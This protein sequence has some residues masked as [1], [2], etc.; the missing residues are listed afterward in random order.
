M[1]IIEDH[2]VELFLQNRDLAEKTRIRYLHAIKIY[3]EFINETPTQWIEEAENEEEDRI[4]MRKRKIKTYQ[5][6]FKKFLESKNYTTWTIKSMIIPIRIFYKE[7]DIEIPDLKI[8]NT[9][10]EETYDDIPSKEDIRL[11]LQFANLKYRAIILLFSSSGMGVA[12]LLSIKYHDLL[13]SLKEYITIP[14]N[15]YIDIEELI[16]LI[17][18]QKET[19]PII[20][21]TWQLTRKKTGKPFI[22]FS[23]PESLDIL[24]E[25]LKSDPPQKLETPLIRGYDPN[26]PLNRR[27]LFKHL[28]R[29]NDKCEFG[30]PHRQIKIRSH[31]IGRKYFTNVL[32]HNGLQQL[33]IDFFLAHTIDKTTSAY[34]KNDIES[35]K[36][37]YI[38]C[39]DNLSIE[40]TEVRI[41]ESEDKKLLNELQAKNVEKDLEL[42][43]TKKRLKRL[44]LYMEQ[45]ER[46]DNLK[47]PDED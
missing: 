43:D 8:K 15:T 38:T 34:F 16:H 42:E 30:K 24:L 18:V 21:P 32:Y 3:S 23:T 26:K 37:Q 12:E 47:K 28:E 19:N 14:Q 41:L 33:S 27:A 10:P 35:L 6:D 36:N 39:I 13:N 4:R 40:D 5:L 29:I 25:Y 17:K 2:L 46:T 31:A 44:E 1:D 45:K 11:A 20:I 7:Y 9:T 22:S